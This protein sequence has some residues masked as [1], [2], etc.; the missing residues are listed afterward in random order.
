MLPPLVLHGHSLSSGVKPARSE[1][2]ADPQTQ[3]SPIR[4]LDRRSNVPE[5]GCRGGPS[6]L[7]K[8]SVCSR[9]RLSFCGGGFDPGGV[10]A[11]PPP[12]EGGGVPKDIKGAKGPPGAGLPVVERLQPNPGGF[13]TERNLSY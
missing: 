6:L 3:N 10:S 8:S 11:S 5:N 13:C 4:P 12:P 2:A 7:P 9:G 1:S